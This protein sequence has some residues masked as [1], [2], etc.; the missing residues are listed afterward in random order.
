MDLP[1]V[2]RLLALLKRHTPADLQKDPYLVALVI[3]LAQQ[4]RRCAAQPLPPSSRFTVG[5][6]L[7]ALSLRLT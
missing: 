4:E 2:H 7:S 6:F 1:G 3:A 5:L